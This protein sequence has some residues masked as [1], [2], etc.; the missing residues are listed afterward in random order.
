MAVLHP[1]EGDLRRGENFWLRVTT[2]SVLFISDAS[3]SLLYRARCLCVHRSLF[4]TVWKF[5]NYSSYAVQ[6]FLTLIFIVQSFFLTHP[7]CLTTNQIKSSHLSCLTQHRCAATKKCFEIFF[8]SS[9]LS[10]GCKVRKLVVVVS[11]ELYLSY[12]TKQTS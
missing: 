11:I 12:V 2:A 6:S 1:R 3:D 5:N 9:F 8:P 4:T 7:R 10:N